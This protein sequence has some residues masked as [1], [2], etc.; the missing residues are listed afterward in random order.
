MPCLAS[1]CTIPAVVL[2]SGFFDLGDGNGRCSHLLHLE[3]RPRC[4]LS[5]TCRTNTY[6]SNGKINEYG[7]AFKELQL[8]GRNQG[9]K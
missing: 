3:D 9:Q 2:V 7:L 1:S 4:A 8:R 6:K 5:H